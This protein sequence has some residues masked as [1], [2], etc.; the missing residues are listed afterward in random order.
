[1][2]RAI[3]GDA[4]DQTMVE[5]RDPLI[6]TI[7]DQRFLI[8]FQLAAG[9]FGA[10]YRAT[11]VLSDAEVALKV[12]LPRLARDRSVVERFRRE[13]KTLANLRDP[14]TITAYELGEAPDGTLYIVMELLHGQSLYEQFRSH[15]RLPWRRVVHIARGVCSSLAEAHAVGIVHRDLKPANIHLETRGNDPD[16][17]KVLD[18]GIAKIVQGSGPEHNELTQAGTM[19]GTVDYMSPEQMVGGEMT[20]S[21]DIY[22]L[23][24][25]M[26]EMI[27]GQT[28]FVDAQTATA[29]LAAVLT[30]TPDPLSS[31]VPVP[32]AVEQIV[33]R[34]LERD[35]GH[36]FADIT[37]LN[38][39][40][41]RVVAGDLGRPIAAVPAT[42]FEPVLTNDATLID[43]RYTGSSQPVLDARGPRYRPGDPVPAMIAPRQLAPM[44]GGGPAPLATP[45]VRPVHAIG[46]QQ[47]IDARQLQPV[48]DDRSSQPI[49]DLAA[50]HR[51]LAGPV[52]QAPVGHASSGHA[53]IGQTSIGHVPVGYAPVIRVPV[54][55]PLVPAGQVS[56][57]QPGRGVVRSSFDMTAAA[58]HDALVRRII[59]IFLFLVVIAAV[60][61]LR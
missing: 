45:P 7:L 36:R 60:W 26:Y 28:P 3:A 42:G 19:I 61:V 50:W 41:A 52:E 47:A 5:R 6:G 40:L 8:E 58:T 27:T 59:W 33:A 48:R 37:E 38:D 17:V 39:A 10:I 4:N 23:G 16:F 34:C 56:A 30:R 1:M 31:H 54:M 49:V 24:I 20:P 25:V 55:Q 46:S 43:I 29:I 13:G 32:V 11:D 14:H 18:F 15:G 53:P 2:V 12:L 9:G 21:S 44:V 51:R 22:T 57:A 35:R